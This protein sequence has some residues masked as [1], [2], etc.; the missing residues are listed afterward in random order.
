MTPGTSRAVAR[1]V[2]KPL[3]MVALR[4]FLVAQVNWERYHG[5][6]LR[7]VHASAA[8]AMV[9]WLTAMLHASPPALLLVAA[10]IC[11]LAAA[12][13]GMME[14]RWQRRRDECTRQESAK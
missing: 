10:A 12:F 13:A 1:L 2:E 3:P 6:R 4:R 9:L 14:W 11:F 7:L 8:S 5:A